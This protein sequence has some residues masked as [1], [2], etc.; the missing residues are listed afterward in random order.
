MGR[1]RRCLPLWP[2]LILALASGLFALSTSVGAVPSPEPAAQRRPN[3]LANPRDLAPGQ[4]LIARRGLGDPNFAES[5]VL[6]FAY[7]ADEGAAGLIINRRTPVPTSEVLPDL[8][9]ARGRQTFLFFG[10]PVLPSG[11]RGLLRTSRAD[12]AGIRVLPDVTLVATPAALEEAV[13]EGATPERLRIYGG[14]AGWG[15]GQLEREIARG[16]WYLNDGQSKVIFAPDP[17]MVWRDQL[18]LVDVIA[19]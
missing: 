17:R 18:R 9:P 10:G 7:S 5:V 6:L 15:P 14:Y 2:T 8:A 16:D 13:A 12:A 11:I 4:F 19:V 3:A 1:R